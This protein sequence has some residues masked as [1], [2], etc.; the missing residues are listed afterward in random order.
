MFNVEVELKSSRTYGTGFIRF[1]LLATTALIAS[2]DNCSSSTSILLF[3]DLFLDFDDA[4][5]I[6]GPASDAGLL[7]VDSAPIIDL[8]RFEEGC[9]KDEGLL[10]WL[11]CCAKFVE[12]GSIA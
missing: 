11:S 10:T 3:T 12:L 2:S 6:N 4:L 8:L 5:S 7:E 9:F 1:A